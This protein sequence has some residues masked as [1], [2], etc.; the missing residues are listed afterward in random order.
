VP[1]PDT[2]VVLLGADDLGVRV[3]QG[4]TPV[5]APPDHPAGGMHKQVRVQT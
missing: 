3:D 1:E 4:L 5:G 2:L